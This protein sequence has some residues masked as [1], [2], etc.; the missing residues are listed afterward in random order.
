[1]KGSRRFYRNID[2][3]GSPLR[4]RRRRRKGDRCHG[5]ASADTTGLPL[6]AIVGLPNVGKS[7]LFHHL[8]GAYVTVSNY[9]GTTVEIT[10]GIMRL[11]CCGSEAGVIDTPGMFSLMP[12]TDEE[13]VA[14]RILMVARPRVVVDVVEAKSLSRMLPLALQLIE[15]GLPLVLDVN[16]LDE[17]EK[18]GVAVDLH[19]LESQLGVPV[20]GTICTSGQGVD[21]LKATLSSLLHD[22]G[23]VRSVH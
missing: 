1:M 6:V 4:T 20:Q 17:A 21:G 13:R 11:D 15:A 23:C 5:L 9:P 2:E 19:A 22:N 8:T 16:L 14:R 3:D 18:H 10:R 7:L 12:L